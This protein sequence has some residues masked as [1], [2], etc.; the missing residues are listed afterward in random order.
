[1]CFIGEQAWVS[2]ST[3]VWIMTKWLLAWPLGTFPMCKTFALFPCHNK[4]PHFVNFV[5]ACDYIFRLK[6]NLTLFNMH[7]FLKWTDWEPQQSVLHTQ[8]L[9][10]SP[11]GSLT[12]H[13]IED[14]TFS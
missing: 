10:A 3:G 2:D 1:M 4:L 6:I 12:W 7:V 14:I 5:F 13:W 8:C 11:T 9:S